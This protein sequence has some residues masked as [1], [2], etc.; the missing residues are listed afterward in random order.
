MSDPKC[1]VLFVDDHE[2]TSHMFTFLLGQDD[3]VVHNAKSVEDALQQATQQD[4]DIYI[5]DK[6]LPDGSGIDLCTRLNELTPGIP[7]LF[8]TGDAYEVHKAE[9]FAAGA[10]G[11]VAKPD[12]DGL[13][14][15]IQRLLSL[16]ECSAGK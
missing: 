16:R 2:D 9:A 4:F 15:N 10:D 14:D 5:L 13:I 11:Y 3:Y 6:H 1:R 8:Y 12:I 7:C